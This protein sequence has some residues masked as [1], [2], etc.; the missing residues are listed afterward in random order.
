MYII[1][2]IYYFIYYLLH[3]LYIIYYHIIFLVVCNFFFYTLISF[4]LLLIIAVSISFCKGLD[5]IHSRRFRN[6][7]EILEKNFFFN[8]HLTHTHFAILSQSTLARQDLSTRDMLACVHVS[9][10]GTLAREHV[11]HAF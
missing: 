1:D 2:I 8:F 10:Q 9:T 11:R 6:D 5:L 4:H 3:I 7:I